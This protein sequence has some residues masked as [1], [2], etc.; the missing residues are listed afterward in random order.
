[1]QEVQILLEEDSKKDIDS[2]K[3]NISQAATKKQR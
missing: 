2:Y 1:M 3:R